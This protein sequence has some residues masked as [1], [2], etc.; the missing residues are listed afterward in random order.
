MTNGTQTPRVVSCP[1]RTCPWVP[2]G[3]SMRGGHHTAAEVAEVADLVSMARTGL[4]D[5][6][7]E[8]LMRQHGEAAVRDSPRPQGAWRDTGSRF[9]RNRRA[10]I[11]LTHRRKDSPRERPTPNPVPDPGVGPRHPHRHRCRLHAAGDRETTGTWMIHS[12]H[13]GAV[14]LTDE[15]ATRLATAILHLVG[16]RADHTAR[17]VSE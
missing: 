7:L 13:A 16:T 1:R 14:R 12:L 8:H 9:P 3:Y 15:Q 11:R 5:E 6:L 4:R 2:V 17:A 10:R